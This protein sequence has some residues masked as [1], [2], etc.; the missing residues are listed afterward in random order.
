MI[1]LTTPHFTGLN[2]AF[3]I[4]VPFLLILSKLKVN[5]VCNR[6]NCFN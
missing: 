2:V 3:I 4:Y 1:M 6:Y 5:M